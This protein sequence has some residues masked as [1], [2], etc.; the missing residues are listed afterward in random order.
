LFIAC[1]LLLVASEQRLKINYGYSVAVPECLSPIPYP[2]L[3]P[4]RIWDP[5]SR[6][7]QQAT[8]EE[9]KNVFLPVIFF[10][11]SNFT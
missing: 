9:E 10:V 6:I 5:K 3:Y 1:G 2:D 4:S 11:A 7:Q 8:K